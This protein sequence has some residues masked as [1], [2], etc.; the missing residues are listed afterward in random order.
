[1]LMSPRYP[2]ATTIRRIIIAIRPEGLRPI[3]RM[4]AAA[5]ILP[6]ALFRFAAAPEGY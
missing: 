5:H 1:M 4:P 2:L 3:L 6:V